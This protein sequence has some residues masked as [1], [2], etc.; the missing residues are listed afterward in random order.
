MTPPSPVKT[1]KSNKVCWGEV[2]HLAELCSAMTTMPE[3]EAENDSEAPILRGSDYSR[4][5]RD[6]LRAWI[7]QCNSTTTCDAVVVGFS[8]PIL[9]PVL[10]GSLTTATEDKVAARNVSRGCTPPSAITSSPTSV[11]TRC[12]RSPLPTRV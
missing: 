1:A 6:T 4:I 11:N 3:H 2:V 12:W 8:N 7:L 10:V 5:A 9:V